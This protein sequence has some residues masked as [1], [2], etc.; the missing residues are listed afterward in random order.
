M[1]KELV[2]YTRTFG[3]PFVASAKR[4]LKKYDIPYREIYID[5]NDEARERV[6]R[7]TGF[8]SVPTLIVAEPGADLPVEEPSPLPQ[9]ASPRGID[10]GAM[11]TEPSEAQFT[12]WLAKHAFINAAEEAAQG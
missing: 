12:T 4:V 11:I 2:M 6:L 7:W 10:R 9:G 1:A 8:L 3:C 5:Q